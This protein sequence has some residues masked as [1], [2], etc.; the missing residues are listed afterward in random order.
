MNDLKAQ[1]KAL[2]IL[3]W[4]QAVVLLVVSITILYIA[5]VVMW[6]VVKFA[7]AA[8]VPLLILGAVGFALWKIFK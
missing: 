4:F 6:S 5:A 1:I 3:Q 2:T 8:L 7:V